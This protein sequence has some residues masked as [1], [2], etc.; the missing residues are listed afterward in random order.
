MQA[1]QQQEERV[2][3]V[4]L[5]SEQHSNRASVSLC[6]QTVSAGVACRT[7]HVSA[8]AATHARQKGR[9]GVRRVEAAEV[10]EKSLR[11]SPTLHLDSLLQEVAVQQRQLCGATDQTP[12]LG[13]QPTRVQC[14]KHWE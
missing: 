8:S 5:M 12:V 11:S 13:Y 14:G 10:H 9:T 2:A 1:R 3:Q 6:V 7:L 4:T